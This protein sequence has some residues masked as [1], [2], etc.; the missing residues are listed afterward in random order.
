MKTWDE[1]FIELL[2]GFDGANPARQE[3]VIRE[4]AQRF[5]IKTFNEPDSNDHYWFWFNT[6]ILN[7]GT[8]QAD[9]ELL[10][11]WPALERFPDHPYDYYFYGDYGNWHP[12]RA[13]IIGTEARLIIPAKPGKTFVGFYPRYSYSRYEYFVSTLPTNSP[14]I[15]KNTEGH[16][17]AGHPI[18]S[19]RLTD[20]TT[21][22]TE[23][24]TVLITARGHPYETSCSYIVEEIM[25]YLTSEDTE[26]KNLLQRNIIQFLPITNPDGVVLGL[27][28]R[29]GLNGINISYGANSDA[30]E[31]KAL[32]GLVEQC[33]PDLWVDIHSWPH[34]GDDGMWCT[35]QWVADGLLEE[36]PDGTW[37]D[38][39]WNVSFLK[40]RNTPEN[41]L[42]QWLVRTLDS[43]GVSL[44]FSWYRRTEQNMREIGIG[45]IHAL[46]QV[47]QKRKP[48][49]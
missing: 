37:Q 23:K 31:A 14:L 29:T 22:D 11:E 45:L 42:W 34:Q 25:Q 46:D 20:P 33:K 2:T 35:H 36:I 8:E 43:G 7:H 49:P 24:P 6:L 28:Q 10:V 18:W 26:A 47:F 4:S 40:D 39:V 16:S 27:N 48:S 13:T 21:S 30:P 15:A 12:A 38:Y 5:R 3:D 44:S 32:L 41:H 19:F 9:V 1:P 17:T